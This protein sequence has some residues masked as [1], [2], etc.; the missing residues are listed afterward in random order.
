MKRRAEIN[1]ERAAL[2]RAARLQKASIRSRSQPVATPSHASEPSQSTSPPPHASAP[3]STVGRRPGATKTGTHRHAVERYAKLK[4]KHRKAKEAGKA[5]RAPTPSRPVEMLVRQAIVFG[6][7]RLGC[8]GPEDDGHTKE[9]VFDRLNSDGVEWVSKGTIQRTLE[10]YRGTGSIERKEKKGPTVKVGLIF[11]LDACIMHRLCTVQRS[12][13]ESVSKGMGWPMTLILYVLTCFVN[14][15][16]LCGRK[17]QQRMV[18]FMVDTPPSTS[19]ESGRSGTVRSVTAGRVHPGLRDRG[20]QRC[21]E[22]GWPEARVRVV[23]ASAGQAS[24][25]LLRAL[26]FEIESR[27]VPMILLSIV[28]SGRRCA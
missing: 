16:S 25:W 17:P 10:H 19:G 26:Y 6:F 5:T 24:D 7:M 23:L 28:L 8:P 13:F 20:G 15:G 18:T 22:G 1:R 4:A 12:F 11:T 2:K 14:C 21:S 9:A 3:K 27:V